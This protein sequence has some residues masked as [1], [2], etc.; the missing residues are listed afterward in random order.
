VSDHKTEA[1]ID[2]VV[3]L[4]PICMCGDPLALAQYVLDMLGRLNVEGWDS[5]K[6][7][8]LPTMFFI[9][10]A[11][12]QD[13]AEHGGSIRCSWLTGKGEDLRDELEKL[14]QSVEDEK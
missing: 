7:E 5:L 8:D 2:R 11:N 13:Y 14:L 10:W 4:L 3:E 9:S 6:W 12:D 1:V